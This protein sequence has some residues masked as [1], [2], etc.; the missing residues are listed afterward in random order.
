MRY[1]L[2]GVGEDGGFL[3]YV[4]A[5]PSRKKAVA[6]VVGL[7]ENTYPT[8]IILEKVRKNDAPIGA[9]SGSTYQRGVTVR[10]TSFVTGQNP[11][12]S[13]YDM[14]VYMGLR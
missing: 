6:A 8:F 2:Y 7:N 4:G 13:I 1:E 12:R 3:G 9:E 10:S 11:T 14:Q 5:Y